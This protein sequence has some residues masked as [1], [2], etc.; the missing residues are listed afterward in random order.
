MSTDLIKIGAIDEIEV[1]LMPDALHLR[2]LLLRQGHLIQQIEDAFDAG[3]AA[4][5]LRNLQSALRDMENSRK[6]A[7]APVL[8][9]AR[10]IDAVCKAFSEQLET[11]KTRISRLLGD[12][13]A[14]EKR[15]QIL[16]AKAARE[17]EE[18]ARI[19]AEAALAAGDFEAANQAADQI[20]NSKNATA[21]AGERTE[22][23]VLRTLWKYELEDITILFRERPDLCRI[24]PFDLAIREEIKLSKK[25]P[26]LRVWSENQAIVK[27]K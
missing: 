20:V 6:D 17:A 22:G 8:D 2:N 16:A 21:E 3:C 12:Y 7:K 9:L 14:A 26:G 18:L 11:E 19:E 27:N 23:T 25:I 5:Q 4:D 10:K 1:T 24:I 13:E 15:K